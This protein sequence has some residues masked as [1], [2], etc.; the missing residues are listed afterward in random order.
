MPNQLRHEALPYRG[1][2]QF[3]TSAVS[4]LRDALDRD[5][6][7]IFLAGGAKLD[8]V[9][10]GLG[11]D[12]DEVTMVATDDH[13]RN[14]SR[15]TTMLHSFSAADHGRR[16]LGLS[17]TVLPGLAVPMLQ[18]AQLAESVLNTPALASWA[19]SITCLYDV[20]RLDADCQLEMRRDHP[21]IR[22]E[23]A[24]NDD[25]DADRLASL[26][27][28]EL[29][30]P[31]PLTARRFDVDGTSLT[32]MR[33]FVRGEARLHG[34]RDDR[35]DDLVLATNEIVTNSVRHGGGHCAL[36]VW[37]DTGGAVVCEVRDH[38]WVRDP[39]VGRLAPSADAAS[40]RGLWLANHLCD[41][42]QIRSAPGGTVVRLV[43]DR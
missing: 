26:Y 5:E 10:D 8:D 43:V 19:M 31:T 34:L 17:E 22:G 24:P 20:N 18:E 42:L 6:R 16:A 27:R 2:E 25:Y 1:H 21:V 30:P 36:A 13:G 38:G 37:A 32:K 14:P 3:V 39:V 23:L 33:Q 12:V 11:T 41:L 40:G 28:A 35:V 9:R 4:V 7:L 29:S 15:I